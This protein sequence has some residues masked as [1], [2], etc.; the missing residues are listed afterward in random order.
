MAGYTGVTGDTTLNG[1]GETVNCR[2]IDLCDGDHFD[3]KEA[4]GHGAG[5]GE[6][7]ITFWGSCVLNLNNCMGP[8]MVLLPLL[9]QQA[10]WLTPTLAL[11]IAYILSSLAA[12]MLCEAMQRIPGNQ[13]FE[14][15][16]EFATTVQYYYGR[17]WYIVFQVFYNLSMQASNIAAMVISA[18][19]VDM[20]VNKVGGH[21]YALDFEHMKIARTVRGLGGDPE[22]LAWCDTTWHSNGSN[23]VDCGAAQSTWVISLGYLICMGICIPFG[24]LNLDDNMWFQW[25]SVIG[26]IVFTA[27]FFGQFIYNMANNDESNASYMLGTNETIPHDVFDTMA[28]FTPKVAAQSQ[29]LGIAVFAYAYVVTIPSWVNEKKAGVNI[30][31]TVW[32]PATV[33]LLMKIATGI[34]G[35]WAFASLDPDDDQDIVK[36]MTRRYQPV[37]T[38]YSA[39]L[40][41]IT[42]LIPGI[43][44]LAVMVRYNLLSGNVCG[45]YMSFFWGVVF[46]WIATAFIYEKDILTSMCNWVAIFVQGYINFVVPA[47]LYRTAVLTHPTG[48]DDHLKDTKSDRQRLLGAIGTG[49]EQARIEVRI[50]SPVNAI[51]RYISI[52]GRRVWL[53]KIRIANFIIIFFSIASTLS[54]F[55]SIFTLVV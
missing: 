25:V 52:C 47:L 16:Y 42:T 14:H 45:R 15:R 34:L 31:V 27:E 26:L 20:F 50:E 55:L 9:N 8:A 24:Y 12:T 39:Y 38:Q 49:S 11:L 29:V 2:T 22:K 40:W 37:L 51:P 4:E 17:N 7:K 18:Q 13:N 44:V 43:P 30:N 10:G 6:K 23:F 41:D 54:I 35:S 36:S 46:P 33:G 28:V 48:E 53:D 5:F 1:D 21:S 32:A 19:V 3:H